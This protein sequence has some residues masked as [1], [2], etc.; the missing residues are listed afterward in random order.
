[1]FPFLINMEIIE[2]LKH[3]NGL[4][5]IPSLKS[6]LLHMY[7]LLPF[8]GVLAE[9]LFSLS[10]SLSIYIYIYNCNHKKISLIHSA[11]SQG[12]Q[13]RILETTFRRLSFSSFIL[14]VQFFLI[15]YNLLY[16]SLYLLHFTIFALHFTIFA[17][18]IHIFRID[19]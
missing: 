9:H 10:L 15:I 8:F 3:L 4:Q 5:P 1:M 12:S 11:S 14:S 6:E 13:F 17:L 18:Y 7:F 16:Q 2:K 19:D